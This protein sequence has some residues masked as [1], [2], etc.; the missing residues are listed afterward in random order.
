[1]L[2]YCVNI[3]YSWENSDKTFILTLIINNFVGITLGLHWQNVWI[4][5]D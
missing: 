5:M 1:M 2:G 3:G 4:T